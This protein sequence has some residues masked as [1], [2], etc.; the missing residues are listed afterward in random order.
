MFSNLKAVSSAFFKSQ[1]IAVVLAAATLAACDNDE[2]LQVLRIRADEEHNRL[3]LLDGNAVSLYHNRSGKLVQRIVLPHWTFVG[4][5][6][7]CPP[8]LTVDTAGAVFVTSNVL[9]VLWRI[10]PERFEVTLLELK[11]DADQDKD[12]GFTGLAFAADGT[13]LAASAVHGSLWRI[14]VGAST[15]EKLASSTP[16]RGVCEPAALL[17][18]MT[19]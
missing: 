6:F 5:R 17:A 19:D 15:A 1:L 18:R 14:D 11:L 3:W 9:P 4:K 13:L 8:D 10:D 2:R 12:V 7:A 16:I